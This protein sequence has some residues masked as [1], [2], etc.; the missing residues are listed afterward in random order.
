[1]PEPY[2]QDTGKVY[3][4]IEQV[5]GELKPDVW[6]DTETGVWGTDITSVVVLKLVDGQ[7]IA[8]LAALSPEDRITIANIAGVPLRMLGCQHD[9]S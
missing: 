5:Y 8:D 9:D 2:D 4:A 6:V 1:M 7:D 3:E